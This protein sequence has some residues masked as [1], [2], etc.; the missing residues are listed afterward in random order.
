MIE[1]RLISI[2][3]FILVGEI[4]SSLAINASGRNR[5]SDQSANT[6]EELDRSFPPKIDGFMTRKWACSSSTVYDGYKYSY[7]LHAYWC[8][9][10]LSDPLGKTSNRITWTFLGTVA[11]KIYM[12]CFVAESS[13][14]EIK[15]IFTFYHFYSLINFHWKSV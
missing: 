1:T 14:S 6:M 12:H 7:I 11:K 4:Q 3:E 2:C 15:K 9:S 13:L 8:C 5:S 10:Q